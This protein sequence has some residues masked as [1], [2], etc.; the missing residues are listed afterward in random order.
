MRVGHA[1]EP[2]GVGSN[3]QVERLLSQ[4][5]RRFEAELG[6]IAWCDTDA[7]LAACDRHEDRLRAI[8]RESIER[9]TGDGLVGGH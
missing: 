5:R 7:F 3:S 4:E 9:A 1:A 8:V 2:G 6:R